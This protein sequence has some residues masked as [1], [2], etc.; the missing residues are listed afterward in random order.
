MKRVNI[1]FIW[2]DYAET[3]PIWLCTKNNYPNFAVFHLYT[4]PK[5]PRMDVG[6]A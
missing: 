2:R 5:K 4:L 1:N 6:P 3:D